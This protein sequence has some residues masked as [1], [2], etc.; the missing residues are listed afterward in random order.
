MLL[1]YLDI[2]GEMVNMNLNIMWLVVSGAPIS[3]VSGKIV[4]QSMDVQYY[5]NQIDINNLHT[6]L[7]HAWTRAVF[8]LG[9]NQGVDLGMDMTRDTRPRDVIAPSV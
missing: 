9:I 5:I 3:A 7:Q 1:R 2:I 6:K 4:L 8:R